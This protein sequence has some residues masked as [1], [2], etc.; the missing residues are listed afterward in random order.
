MT[1][2]DFSTRLPITPITPVIA[3]QFMRYYR[4]QGV[5]LDVA[6]ALVYGKP[7]ALPV[8]LQRQAA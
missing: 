3:A 4:A 1:H 8:T 2:V 5:S 7:I 6:Y